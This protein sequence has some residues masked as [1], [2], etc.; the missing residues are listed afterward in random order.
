MLQFSRYGWIRIG[1][2]N[3]CL[4][5]L[6]GTLMRYKILFEFPW[7]NQ[8]HLLHAHSHFA[9]AGW[10][11]HSLLVMI[12]SWLARMRGW[13]FL[14]ATLYQRLILI[15]LICSYGLLVSFAL[16]GY[17]PIS[18]TFSIGAVITHGVFIYSFFRDS[19]G[20]KHPSLKWFRAAFWFYLLSCVGI[21][22]LAY[23]M[24]Y[25]PFSTKTYLFS[26]YFY[27]HFQYNGWFF[28]ACMGLLTDWLVRNEPADLPRRKDGFL[29]FWITC[30]PT[31]LL[32]ALWL[33]LP[34][35]LLLIIALAAILQLI[36]FLQLW[37]R[38]VYSPA[39]KSANVGKLM[40]VLCVLILLAL[41]VKVLLQ[42][43]S[44]VPKISEMAFGF[45]HIVIAYLHLVLLCIVSL[46]LLLYFRMEKIFPRTRSYI[47]AVAVFAILAY[48]NEL[49]LA[50]QGIASFSY[51]PVPGGHQVLLFVSAGLLLTALF[52]LIISSRKL[53]KN[54]V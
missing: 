36:A 1:L 52:I 8:G 21:M 48:L 5:A 20:I 24:V 50:I 19:H 51:V 14:K 13:D 16:F 43:G 17:H 26:I 15:N 12:S 23:L 29:L 54:Q 11:G 4:V 42:T 38:L 31:L 2:V 18:N 32:S 35:W 6:M 25:G 33:D 22:S 10:V 40:Q 45:R 46:F 9:F 53:A 34:L 7:L 30:I 27:L 28:F 3:L 49:T 47:V 37:K 39:F 41:A 44:T